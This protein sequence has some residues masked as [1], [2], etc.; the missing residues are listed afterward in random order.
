MKKWQNWMLQGF[1]LAGQIGNFALQNQWGGGKT[2]QIIA[3]GLSLVQMIG[4]LLAHQ[5][6]PDGTPASQP[7]VKQ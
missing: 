1:A 4:A 3:G 6:N 7:Y 2:P 5:F